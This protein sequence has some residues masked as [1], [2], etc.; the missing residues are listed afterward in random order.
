M[1]SKTSFFNK[2]LYKK[3]ISRTWIAGLLYLVILLLTL[4]VTYIISIADWDNQYLADTGYTK[5]MYLFMHMADTPTVAF[6]SVIAIVLAAITF[7]FLFNKRDNYM[8]HAF[9]ISRKSAYVT[10]IASILTVAIIPVLI[11]SII[12]T[13]IAMTVDTIAL[14]GIWYW[15]LI[16][17]VSTVLFL[18]IAMLALMVSGQLVTAIIFYA[19]FCALYYLIEL[20]FRIT[21]TML[22]FGMSQCLTSQVPRILTP[23][24]FIPRF[25][26]LDYKALSDYNGYLRKFTMYMEGG[27]Y[28]AIYF[29]AA[30]VLLI[31]S[32]LLY[33]YKKL[34]TVHDFISVPFMKPVFTIGMSFF[35]S[36]VAGAFASGMYAAT[37]NHTYSSKFAVAIIAAIIIGAII[38]FATQMMIEKTI[39]VFN[40]KKLIYCGGY[41]AAALVFLIC[42]RLDAFNIENKVPSADDVEWV[43]IQSQYSMVYTDEDE[44]NT[45]ISLHKNFLQDKK[46][47]RDVNVKYE[48]VPGTYFTIKYKLKNGNT[49]IRQ[50]DVVDTE[51]EDVS[52]NYVAATQPILDFLNNPTIIKEHIIGNIWND[53]YVKDMYFSTYTFNQYNQ[54]FDYYAEYF[55]YLSE[56][57]KME[58]YNKVYDALIQDI[59]E[60]KLFRTTFAGYGYTDSNTALYND[61]SFTV[62]NDDVEYFSDEGTFYENPY[63]DPY[64]RRYVYEGDDERHEQN[65]YCQLTTDCVHT[66][67]ALKDEEF[68]YND[69]EIITYTEYNRLMGYDYCEDDYY[70][71]EEI[72]D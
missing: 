11:V 51:S 24:L 60:G 25:C 61:F 50:Y 6:A 12:M 69:D 57:E 9:P 42:L 54:E 71:D 17:I 19:I 8:M 66:L 39:R 33:K 16:V 70:E 52:A 59:D 64:S 3:N 18:S 1:Q 37:G 34:E 56:Y 49:I 36:M 21:A 30:I 26:N 20:A 35:I 22:M 28:L 27:N 53:C 40:V 45:A 41:S 58:K 10:G 13:I 29:V 55:M 31:V 47:L 4:P 15:A 5:G 63:D 65:I 67:K 38:F 14:G 7:W 68:Y 23:S 44:I 72:Y 62:A 43:G 46:E 48:D 2:A 32:F